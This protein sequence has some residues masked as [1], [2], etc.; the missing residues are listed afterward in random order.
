MRDRVTTNG[1]TWSRK[2]Y[3]GLHRLARV[4]FSFFCSDDTHIHYSHLVIPYTGLHYIVDNSNQSSL[5]FI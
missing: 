4:S 2:R 3:R 5:K 1:Y